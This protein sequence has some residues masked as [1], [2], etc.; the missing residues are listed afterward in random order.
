MPTYRS[1][2][3]IL[4]TSTPHQRVDTGKSTHSVWAPDI[5]A[6]FYVLLQLLLERTHLRLLREL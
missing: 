5:G 4:R 1:V 6:R 3:T 2:S